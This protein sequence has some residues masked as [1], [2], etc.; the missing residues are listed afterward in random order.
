MDNEQLIMERLDRIEAWL[1]P[2]ADHARSMNELKDDLTPLAK[3]AFQL[4]I[5][6]LADVESGFKLEDFLTLFKRMLKNIRNI[7]FA[8]N[9]LEKIVDLI[10]TLK[11]LMNSTVPHMISYLD[12]LEQRGVFRTY[13]AMLDVRANIAAAYTSEDMDQI[14]KGVIALLGFFKKVTAPQVLSFLDK[15]ACL[16]TELDLQN[17]KA[18]GPVGLLSA[19]TSKEVKEGL[20]ILVELTRTMGKLKND[21]LNGGESS[22]L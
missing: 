18:V 13:R 9:Q 7:I 19:C 12:N 5:N 6:E 22:S 17:C 3:N 2:M 8:L 16:S 11:P 1:G 14:G 20:G 10:K 15:M 21:G 4:L